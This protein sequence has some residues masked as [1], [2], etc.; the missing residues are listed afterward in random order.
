MK[1]P[2]P[3]CFGIINEGPYRANDRMT[4]CNITKLDEILFPKS[5]G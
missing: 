1:E 3:E 2:L 4:P 5:D